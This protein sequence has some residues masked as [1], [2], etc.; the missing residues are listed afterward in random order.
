METPQSEITNL[1][2]DEIIG[3]LKEVLGLLESTPIKIMPLEGRGSE[4]SFYRLYWDQTHSAILI[5]Y[6]PKRIENTYY[7]DMALFLHQIGI[8]VPHLIHHNPNLCFVLMEDLG[9]KLLYD[10]REEN[11][12][13]RRALYQKVLSTIYRLHVFPLKDFPVGKVRMMEGFSPE[14]YHW[15]QDYFLNHFVKEVCGIELTNSFR[16]ELDLEFSGLV[17]SLSLTTQC[18]IHRDLQSQNV[19]VRDRDIFL[20]DFQG[21]RLGSPLYDLGSLLCDPY[22]NLTDQER[23]DLLS[24]YYTLSKEN[25]NWEAFQKSFWE[26]S[27]QRLMQ[28]LGAYGF[29]GLRKGLK[30]YLGHIPTGLN[31][32]HLAASHTALLPKLLE[33][34]LTCQKVISRMKLH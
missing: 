22:V 29:L 3:S 20:I 16:R 19:M 15:E 13:M 8:P 17:E 25:L 26:A 30:T 27:A 11:W 7:A 14:L 21:M 6:S 1:K 34:S 18:L 2:Y 4:R 28:A 5:H 32:L 10:L 9:D 33:L 31:R 12:E 23:E 24:F